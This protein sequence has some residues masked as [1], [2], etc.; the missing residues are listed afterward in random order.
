MDDVE[1]AEMEELGSMICWGNL[2]SFLQGEI[3]DAY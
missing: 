2:Q 1:I 3:E